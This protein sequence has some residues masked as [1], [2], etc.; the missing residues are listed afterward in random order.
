MRHSK[1]QAATATYFSLPLVGLLLLMAAVATAAPNGAIKSNTPVVLD[2]GRSTLLHFQRMRRVEVIEPELIEVV[3][4]SLDD[5][6]VYGKKPGQTTMYVWDK[7][8]IHQF[9]ITVTG[10]T[11]ADQ[12]I[13]DLRKVLGDGLRYTAAGERAVVVEGTLSAVEAERA[14]SIIAASSKGAVEIVDLIRGEGDTTAGAT[15]LADS[16]R[17]VLGDKLQYVVWN[18]NTLLVQ[19]A[20]GDPAATERARKLL[21]AAGGHGIN[22]VDLIETNEAVGVAPLQDIAAAVGSK[23]TVRS[24][25]GRTV[26]VEGTVTSAAELADVNKILDTFS[27]QAKIVNLVRLMEPRRDINEC[28]ALLQ[29]IVGSGCTV[30]VMDGDSICIEGGRATK[31]ELDA[32]RE[33]IARVPMPYQ[34]VDLLHIAKPDKRQIICH[35]RVVDINKGNLKRLGVNWGQ[36]SIDDN[37]VTF[38]DQPWLVEAL[39][40]GFT[41]GISGVFNALNIG[42]QLDLLAQKNVARI[43]SEPN[44]LVDDGGQ[45]SMLVGGEIPV[46]IAQPTSGGST[47]VTIEW[48]PYGVQL[49]VEPTILE[50]SNRIAMK[51]VPEV[52]SLDFGNAITIGGFVVPALRSRKTA[53]ELTITAGQTLII[54]GLLQSEDVK[55]VRKIPLLG[56]LPIIGRLFQRKEFQQGESELV[57][58]VTPEIM[59]RTAEKAEQQ[60]K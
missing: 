44:L 59:D 18:N 56:D 37:T 28:V 42:A 7:V 26:A 16:L 17:K 2:E 35:V 25:Q 31:E 4:A 54:G 5:L 47:T 41:D 53:S 34:V 52:S 33:I 32:L 45:A 29:G 46:P 3:V 43:L 20:L 57:I 48:K 14:R 12:L 27:G 50:N 10:N 58:T 24:I 9:E 40:S 51:I 30:R 22:I 11:P 23:F 19:G 60:F 55:S 36:L 8:G 1:Y 21:A 49:S 13:Q 6:S 39:P 38:V 15:A